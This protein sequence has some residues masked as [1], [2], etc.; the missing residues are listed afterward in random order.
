MTY[1]PNNQLDDSRSNIKYGWDIINYGR[2]ISTNDPYDSGRIKVRIKGMDDKFDDADIPFCEP[3]L[4]KFLNIIPK[5]DEMVKIILFNTDE[6]HGR[7]EWVGPVISQV[8]N[9]K[10]EHYLNST[11][12]TEYGIGNPEE[13]VT[14][15]PEAEGAYPTKEEIAFQGRDNTDMI[16]RDREILLRA[17]KFEYG[18]NKKTNRKN[19]AYIQ[20]NYTNNDTDSVMNFVADKINF[21]SHKGSPKFGAI[22][23]EAQQKRINEEAHP[24][25]FGDELVKFLELIKAY[26]AGHIH[27]T[28]LPSALNSGKKEDILAFDLQKIISK[29]IK[30]N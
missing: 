19:P 3:L 7:R 18:N 14:K 12:T 9:L 21:I 16:F 17:G 29:H 15:I 13:G 1:I 4:P 28:N 30:V 23:D 11:N 10:K 27:A 8:Y 20:L 26:V 2:V 5:V 22:I 25:A 6:P 24:V